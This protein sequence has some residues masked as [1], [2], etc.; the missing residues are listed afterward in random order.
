MQ[1]QEEESR[2]D[3]WLFYITAGKLPPARMQSM[4]E[5][6]KERRLRRLSRQFWGLLVLCFV[7]GLVSLYLSHQEFLRPVCLRSILDS[8]GHALIVASLL[9][10]TVDVY[11]K[12]RLLKEASLDIS[13]YLIGYALPEE[14]QDKIKEAMR[15]DLVRRDLTVRYT[16]SPVS[17][18]P[19]KLL[20]TVV[21][22][23]QVENVSNHEVDYQPR[24]DFATHLKPRTLDMRVDSQADDRADDMG[25]DLSPDE[26]TSP[27]VSVYSLRPFKVRPKSKNPELRYLCEIRYEIEVPVE[28]GD[29]FYF[30]HP[31]IDVTLEVKWPP[32]IEFFGPGEAS[33]EN[34][35]YFK[36]GFL[37]G[38]EISWRW[39]RMAERP[40][41][42][43]TQ[44]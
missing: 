5:E 14:I 27:Q 29:S 16:L 18:E 4:T 34:R 33:N 43:P 3:E 36:K 8:L 39:R 15:I 32:N 20:A 6:E 38:E 40:S 26:K 31:T 21:Y 2:G 9:A 30:N 37:R 24:M 22:A 10:A 28:Y 41:E 12:R 25:K 7:L 44:D 11:M 42:R 1:R 17:E 35:W 19:D 13:K 23:Y